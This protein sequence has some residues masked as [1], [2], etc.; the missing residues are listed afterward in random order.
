MNLSE[1]QKQFLAAARNGSL[2]VLQ[3]MVAVGADVNTRGKSEITALHEAAQRGFSEIALWLIDHGAT[4]DSRTT[5]QPGYPG[6]ESPLLLAVESGHVELARILLDKGA[7]PNLK[8]SDGN[9]CLELAV[10]SGNLSLVDSLLQKGAQ[11]NPRGGFTPLCNALCAKQIEVARHLIVHGAR[12]DAILQPFSTPL[13]NFIAGIKWLPAVNLL[14]ECG[15]SAFLLDQRRLTS[16]HSATL[17]FAT[18]KVEWRGRGEVSRC[19]VEEPEDA[20]PVIRKLIEIGVDPNLRDK[21]GLSSLDYAR[22]M[23]AGTLINLMGGSVSGQ[24]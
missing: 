11:V 15:A 8:S 6:A 1:S 16:L 19:A 5:A 13:F 23:R 9:S 22:R 2:F 17:S 20:I 4:I 7:N 3:S 18:R 24:V 12:V 10:Q 14:L 21:D